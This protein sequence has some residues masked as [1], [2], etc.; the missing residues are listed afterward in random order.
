MLLFK[1]IDAEMIN[2]NISHTKNN[3]MQNSSI[4]DTW[5]EDSESVHAMDFNRRIKRE[6]SEDI[7][8]PSTPVA[9]DYKIEDLFT[10]VPK[11]NNTESFHFEH[12]L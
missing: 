7:T 2:S 5:L 11:G 1:T 4:G 9:N 10:P 6:K 12:K 3:S 8:L